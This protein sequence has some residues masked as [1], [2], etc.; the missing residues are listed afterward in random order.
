MRLVRRTDTLG[1]DV[2]FPATSQEGVDLGSEGGT[3][4]EGEQV[5]GEKAG[6]REKDMEGG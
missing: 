3:E 4:E 2:W 5:R 1:K 6:K